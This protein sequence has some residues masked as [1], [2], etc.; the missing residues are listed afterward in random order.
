MRVETVAGIQARTSSTRLARKVLADLCGKPLIERV[1]ERARAASLVDRVVVLTST[2]PSDDALAEVLAARG[3]PFRRGP[4]AD[5][6]ARYLAL[7]EEFDPLYLVRVCGDCPF[8]DPDFIDLQLGALRAFKADL[9]YA[10]DIG[11]IEG[12]LGGQPAFSV[13]ALRRSLASDERRDKEH[14]SSFYFFENRHRFSVVEIEVD[15]VYHRPGLRLSVDE[16]PDL[17]LARR[18]WEAVDARGDGSFP[19]ERALTWLDRHPEVRAL[20]QGVRDS[21]DTGALRVLERRGTAREEDS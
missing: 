21:A 6:R 11:A 13:R 9:V 16:S 4:L 18:V 17:E 5:V 1:F 3:I 14:V 10:T 20:N 2:D 19:L 8:V 15:A 7:V 12:T